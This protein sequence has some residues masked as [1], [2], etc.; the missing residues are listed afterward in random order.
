MINS[1]YKLSV[2]VSV[3]QDENNDIT[4]CIYNISYGHR[5]AYNSARRTNNDVSA[6]KT[7]N[8]IITIII[9]AIAARGSCDYQ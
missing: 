1:G 6:M 2:R 3:P 4:K 5:N 9:F 8:K 7:G